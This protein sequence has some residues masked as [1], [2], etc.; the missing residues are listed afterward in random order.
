[1][2]LRAGIIGIFLLGAGCAAPATSAGSR[3]AEHSSRPASL[4]QF[5]TVDML[6]RG[7]FDGPTTAQQLGRHGDFGLGGFQ[8]L[9]GELA[10]LDGVVYRF[11]SDGVLRI[12]QPGDLIPFAAVTT[13]RAD[14]RST[15]RSP[16]ADFAELQASVTTA[17][18]DQT[19]ML[20]VKIHGTFTA[21]KTRSPRRQT[22]PYPLL[23]EAIK[24]Q[25]EFVYT[26]IRGT[27]IGFRLPVYLGT[28]NATGYHFHFVSD[29]RRVGGHV[30]D[31]AVDEATVELQRIDQLQLHVPPESH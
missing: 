11:R 13:F 22:K 15:I 18:P 23:S 21:I 29:D 10:V 5:G 26:N 16:L 9:D 14:Q 6:N 3:A 24:T 27:L 8:A 30:L 1:M 20:A 12:A 19:R 2:Q 17:A 28:T 7:L 4:V 31:V 25:A